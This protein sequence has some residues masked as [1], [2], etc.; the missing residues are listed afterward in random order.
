ME[1]FKH[2]WRSIPATIRKPIILV[3][4]MVFVVA[5][6]LTGWLPGPGGI[7]LFLVGIA[8]LA[9]EFEWA[10]RLRD[11]V[12]D[13]IRQLGI[14]YRRHKIV[15]TVVLVLCVAIFAGLSFLIYRTL[16]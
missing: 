13:R 3:I 6:A 14:V 9:T 15:G 10:K 8:V 16:R 1:R 11:A 5:A 2:R 4:G 7:P 12:V